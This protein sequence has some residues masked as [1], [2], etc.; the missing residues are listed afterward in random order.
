MV[1]SVYF[2]VPNYKNNISQLIVKN[3]RNIKSIE[4]ESQELINSIDRT[5]LTGNKIISKDGI[6]VFYKK[7]E[8]YIE[9]ITSKRDITGRPAIIGIDSK[10]PTLSSNYNVEDWIFEICDRI[11]NFS[12]KFELSIQEEQLDVIRSSLLEI[13][14]INQRKKRFLY[15]IKL[16]LLL[17]FPI[18][19]AFIIQQFFLKAHIL[20]IGV[21][22]SIN[23]LIIMLSI[24]K[25]R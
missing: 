19:I 22:I 2:Y 10:V 5:K 1:F 4:T 15:L 14:Y 9:A 18:L 20:T 17:I 21:L 12:T 13:Y 3:G 24:K 7:S 8:F 6:D 25:W 11:Q 23:N 16:G